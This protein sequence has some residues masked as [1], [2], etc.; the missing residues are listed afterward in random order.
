MRRP[1][2][3]Y[4]PHRAVKIMQN[5]MALFG[6]LGLFYYLLQFVFV[7]YG[8]NSW[9]DGTQT[10]DYSEGGSGNR[11]LCGRSLSSSSTIDN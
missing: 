8:L 7:V 2:N 5:N 9:A 10:E 4:A 3:F 6:C 1:A 11:L